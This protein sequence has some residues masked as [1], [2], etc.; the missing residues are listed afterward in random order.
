MKVIDNVEYFSINEIIDKIR[1]MIQQEISAE[2]I[3]VYFEKSIIIGKKI[4]NE[5][6]GDQNA[7]VDLSIELKGNS[8]E[9]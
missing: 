1:E 9:F 5:W 7:I 8:I 6:Y 2:E 4:E 3:R